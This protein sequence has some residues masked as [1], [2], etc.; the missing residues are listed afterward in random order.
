LSIALN[1][2]FKSRNAQTA[3]AINATISKDYFLMHTKI[4]YQF[5]QKR[6]TSFVQIHN[7]FNR[8][9]SDL[10]GAIMP[11]RWISAGISANF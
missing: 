9:Y 8:N 1:G 10:L 6:I 4:A 5:L 11:D 3:S 7:A 2:L